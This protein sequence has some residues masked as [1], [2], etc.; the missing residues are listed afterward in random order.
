MDDI[1]SHLIEPTQSTKSSTYKEKLIRHISRV[2]PS[3]SGQSKPERGRSSAG[4][5]GRYRKSPLAR[6]FV[7]LKDDEDHDDF[8]TGNILD[9]KIFY[10]NFTAQTT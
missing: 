7:G 9:W 5:T 6:F 8:Y 2:F 4:T 10:V 1:K 3:C